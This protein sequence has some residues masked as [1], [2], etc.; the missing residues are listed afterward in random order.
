MWECFG[1]LLKVFHKPESIS[2]LSHCKKLI[3]LIVLKIFL[4]SKVYFNGTVTHDETSQRYADKV[5]VFWM[6][7]PYVKF[8]RLDHDPANMTYQN[9]SQGPKFSV[10]IFYKI[11]IIIIIIIINY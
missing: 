3:G 9:T 7:P 11:I 2:F 6:I 8:S 10:S 5:N 4:S 1:L